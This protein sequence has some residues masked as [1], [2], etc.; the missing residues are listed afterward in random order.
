M[1]RASIRRMAIALTIAVGATFLPAIS[2]ADEVGQA[3]S[4]AEL[5]SAGLTETEIEAFSEYLENESEYQE[6][7]ETSPLVVDGNDASLP[8]AGTVPEIGIFTTN[9]VETRDNRIGALYFSDIP[10]TAHVHCT[11]NYIGGKFWATAHHCV[12]GRTRNVG[13]IEQAD[14]EYAGI[15]NIYTKSGDYDI[16]L[17]KVGSGIGA[18][19]FSLSSTRPNV[20]KN[21]EIVGYAGVNRFSSKSTLEVL[22]SNTQVDYT[23]PPRTY[24]D[25]FLSK[26][27]APLNYITS[28][29]DSGASVW[30]GDVMF[31]IHSGSNRVD[32]AYAANVAPHIPW[33]Q[34][35]MSANSNSSSY[36]ILQAFRGGLATSYVRIADLD[37]LF[38]GSS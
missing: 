32:R 17:I 22:I 26:P 12:D 11:A 27:V 36:E 8:T 5:K 18:Q 29:G 14:G 31:G 37:D 9:P 3:P 38:V 15:E 4:E 7:V 24:Y 35:T 16:A 25:T 10:G 19:Q 23:D 6:T 21:L 30:S 33:V 13:F 1:K 20:G 28:G 2:T 34:Q